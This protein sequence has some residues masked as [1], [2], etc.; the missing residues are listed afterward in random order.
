MKKYFAVTAMLILSVL[1][2]SCGSSSPAGPAGATVYTAKFQNGVYPTAAYAGSADTGL[3]QV[4]PDLNFSTIATNWAGFFVT[5]AIEHYVIRYDLSSIVPSNVKVTKA[6]LTVKCSTV[7]GAVS[8]TYT[9]YALTT[10]NSI[11]NATWNSSDTGTPWTAPGG[12]FGAAAKS[13]SVMM[14]TPGIYVFSLD[15]DMVKSW[16][17]SPSTNYGIV[18]K[19]A[20]ET[21]PRAE[22]VIINDD[23]GST[24]DRPLL[25]V[26]Y[27]LP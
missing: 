15:T 16:I 10:A 7:A 6:Y 11:S 19:G 14:N 20:N 12:D 2:A 24:A 8:N 21:G 9:A 27:T 13:S 25:T 17:S 26:E 5:G 23:N 1:A 4:N 18:L 3:Y 22:V